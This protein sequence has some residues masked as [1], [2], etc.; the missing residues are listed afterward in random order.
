MD[1]AI[2]TLD[3][4]DAADAAE[5]I[6]AAAARNQPLGV[7]GAGTKR[8]LGR[9]APSP[10]EL[11][12]RALTGVT[13]YEPEELVLS[14]RAGTPLRDVLTLLDANGQQLAFEPLDHALLFGGETCAATI[15][16]VI[17]VNASGP[18]RIKAGAA[19]D[20]LLGFHCVTG[21]G[22]IV[23]SGGRVMKNV[24]GYDLSKLVTGSFGTLALLTD[25]TLKV[26]PKAETEQTLLLLGL[27]EGQAVAQ[28]RR[29]SG[30]SNEVSSF[31]MLPAGAAPLCRV[32]TV[33]ALRIEGPEVSVATRRDALAA[34]LRDSGARF[35]T[36]P[37]AESAAFWAALRDAAPVAGHSGQ[38]W[39]LSLA[40]TDG[41]RA[42]ARLRETGAPILAHFYDW[43]GGL[44]WLCLEPAADAHAPAVRAAVDAFGGHATLIRASD[45][46]RARV[47]VF[48]PQPPPLAALS[49]RVKESF[50]PAHVLERGR[51]RA[52]V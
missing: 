46:T 13:L 23:K 14:A 47:E 5:A 39:R 35:E 7:I 42:L 36:L 41:V 44:V 45:E 20:H 12:T 33:A 4:R 25:V 31:A 11:S 26:L 15:G 9:H 30:T 18:R 49:R 17:A 16:G 34:A 40:P 1:A 3:I 2:A 38:V 21:R 8:R 24:T 51:M 6:R 50:D 19:R 22:E 28:L 48:H 37:F 43:A 29:A 32:E 52:E 27:D 10:R